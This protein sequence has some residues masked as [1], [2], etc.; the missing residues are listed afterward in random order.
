MECYRNLAAVGAEGIAISDCLNFGSPEDPMVMG[1]LVLSCRGLSDAATALGTPVVSGNVS[2]YNQTG[3]QAIDP[4]PTVAMVGH[5]ADVTKAG[6]L[7]VDQAGLD[8]WLFG[9]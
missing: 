1:Q 2:L 5:I 4:T 6:R 9:V 3:D 8:V 7:G